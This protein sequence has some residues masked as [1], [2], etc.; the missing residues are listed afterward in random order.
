MAGS[1]LRAHSRARG[2]KV[3]IREVQ[4]LRR[5]RNRD[6]QISIPGLQHTFELTYLAG[7]LLK[8][9]VARIILTF[10][11]TLLRALSITICSRSHGR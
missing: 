9:R 4:V 6:Y 8:E 11:S 7:R 10:C 2:T 5:G 1:L 3:S